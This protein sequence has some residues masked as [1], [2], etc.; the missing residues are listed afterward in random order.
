MCRNGTAEG[1]TRRA[2][3]FRHTSSHAKPCARLNKEPHLRNKSFMPS[4]SNA[5]E[6]RSVWSRGLLCA[7][8]MT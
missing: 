8:E 7:V 6:K 1:K 4:M 5:S 2:P 3:P